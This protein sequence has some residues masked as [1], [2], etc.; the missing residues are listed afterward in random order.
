MPAPDPAD[1]VYCRGKVR[2]PSRRVAAENLN[3]VKGNHKRHKHERGALAVYE[4]QRCGGFHIGNKVRDRDGTPKAGRPK[5][6]PPEPV[7][8]LDEDEAA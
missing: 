4:C 3:R 7:L 6:A 1:V 8:E 5:P 2:H